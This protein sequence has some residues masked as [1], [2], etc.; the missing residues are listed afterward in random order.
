MK[1]LVQLFLAGTAVVVPFAV[2]VYIIQAVGTWL[3]RI[4]QPVV[5]SFL[6][7]DANLV[8]WQQWAIG[9][10]A[11]LLVIAG[12]LLIGLLTRFWLFRQVLGLLEKLFQRVPGVKTIY[13]S[14][15]DVL[16]LFGR[17]SKRMGKAVLYTPPG[18]QVSLLA[19]RTSE[20]PAGL[21]PEE[22]K[23][24]IFVPLAYMIGGPVLYVPAAHVRELD[25]SVERALKLATT[26]QIG[27]GAEVPA[28]APPATRG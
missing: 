16:R 10:L 9:A 7:K 11:M 27:T 23:V 25:L 22:R 19:I 2:T 24:A 20:Q 5:T 13:E 12:I 26:A 15:R 17:D 4:G 8:N 21:P 3:I 18:T 1:K 14:V 28:D 6:P